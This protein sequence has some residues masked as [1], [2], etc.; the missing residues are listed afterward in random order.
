MWL[1]NCY[2]CA[3]NFAKLI[4]LGF[5]RS[6]KKTG[7]EVTNSEKSVEGQNASRECDKKGERSKGLN[8]IKP[9][10]NIISH[11]D[12]PVPRKNRPSNKIKG[13]NSFK[14]LFYSFYNDSFYQRT[15]KPLLRVFS[16]IKNVEILPLKGGAISVKG[17]Q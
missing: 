1:L 4:R 10:F 5:N 16:V 12:A 9:L 8:C 14:N 17:Y 2:I 3:M 13:S 7:Y 15:Y 6:R 11:Y